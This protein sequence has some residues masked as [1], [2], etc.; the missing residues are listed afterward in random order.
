MTAITDLTWDN[1]YGRLPEAFHQRVTPTPVPDPY[2]VAWNEG[3]AAELGWPGD[4]RDPETLAVLAGN[5]VVDAMD[6][7]A[8]AYAGHQF[9]SWVPELGDGRAII[10]GEL[11][12]PSGVHQELQLKGAGLTRWSRM[13][14]G[15]AVL[16]ST[17]REYLASAAMHGLGIPTT[18]ALAI[19][20]SDMPVHRERTESAAILTR[21]APTHIRFG[22]FEYLAAR[23]MATERQQLADFVIERF[24]PELFALPVAERYAAWYTTV[25][26]RTARLMAAWI[27]VGFAHGVMNTDNFSILGLTLDYGP[28]GWLDGYDPTLIC[29]HSDW[30]G[31]YAFDQQPI[32]GL[33]NCARLGEALHPL[34]DEPAAMAALEG[35][36]VAYETEVAARMRAKLGLEIA[37]D[38]DVS[39][40]TAFLELMRGVGAD[41]TRTFRALSRWDADDDASATPLRHELAGTTGLDRWLEQ[42]RARLTR[43]SRRAAARHAAMLATNPKYVLRN[44]VAQEAIQNAETRNVGLVD[45]IRRLLERPFDEHPGMARYAAKPPDWARDIVVSCSS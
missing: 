27:A 28:Y 33:W 36:R 41:Y 24:H 15:R 38:D 39:L 34:I 20:G 5:R 29:N 18:R 26:E 16:R 23:R 43:E 17:I 35:Y 22:T 7:I 8:S 31:R 21:V 11:V 12:S 45:E 3:L 13:G 1:A 14:D 9:G 42:Y 37:A 25:V 44:W 30:A 32:V 19:V 10:L 40:A 4:L 6:P 2:P